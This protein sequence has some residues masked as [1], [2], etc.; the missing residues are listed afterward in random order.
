MT[1]STEG[2]P[3]TAPP[4]PKVIYV[5]GA[6]R[7]G[8][9]I[10]GVALGNCEGVFYAGELDKW[11]PRSGR[12]AHEG[13]ER[14]GFW[15]EVRAR[16]PHAA[17]LFGREAHNTLERSS[18][19]LRLRTLRRRR[20]LRPRFLEV[21]E[22]LYQAI[23]AT[24]DAS[25]VVDSSHYP[26]RA[27]E[28]QRLGGIEMHLLFLV[29]DPQS[30]VASFD[31]EDVPEPRFGEAKTNAYLW[32]TYLLSLRAFLR[33]PRER[34]MLVRHEDFLTDPEG[35]LRAILDRSGS[36]APLPDLERLDTGFP[37]QGN[38]LIAAQRIALRR[39]AGKPRRA[40]RLTALCQL[41]WAAVFSR[42]EPVATGSAPV[43]DA[44]KGASARRYDPRDGS[45][46]VSGRGAGG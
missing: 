27:R 37:L 9:T 21:A 35:V 29:R 36:A 13:S 46:G 26:L 10:L 17:E 32:L 4:R 7:S 41:P 33:H 18:S 16:V 14:Q 8:S 24:A 20:R 39:G 34:R 3:T 19:L 44:G 42:L 6:G 40:R 45:S 25:H 1:S 5:M 43:E 23:A 12:P 30:I 15:N 2:S 28:L 31:R 22:A 11:L 38:R